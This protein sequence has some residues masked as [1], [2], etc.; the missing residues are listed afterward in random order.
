[1]PGTDSRKASAGS[2]E[3]YAIPRPFQPNFSEHFS[4]C[5]R[6]HFGLIVIASLPDTIEKNDS[7]PVS[8]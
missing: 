1:M 2:R 4:S 5:E 8:F 7:Q 6:E 3:G